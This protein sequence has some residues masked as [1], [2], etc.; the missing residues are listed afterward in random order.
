MQRIVIASWMISRFGNT[1]VLRTM[2][3]MRKA[4]LDALHDLGSIA[5]IRPAPRRRAS[6]CAIGGPYGVGT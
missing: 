5:W 4:R 2:W 6:Q 3:Q 1:I